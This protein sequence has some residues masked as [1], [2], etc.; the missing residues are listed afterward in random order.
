MAIVDSIMNLLT[1]QTIT[2]LADRLGAPPSAVQ[3]GIGTSITAL[4]IGIANRGRDSDFVSQVFDLVKG[5]D[6]QDILKTLPNLASGAGASS[7]A[8]EE[9]MKLSSLVL[10]GQQSSI[11]NFIGRQSGLT[12][13]AGRELMSLAAALTAGFLGYRVRDTGLAAFSFAYTIRS[14]ASKI[15]GLLPPGLP[16]LL[17]AV[18]I[19][20]ELGTAEGSAGKGGGRK[21]AYALIGLLLLVLIAWLVSHGGN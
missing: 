1:R 7:A 5:A 14:E 13:D 21:L 19:P 15:Q 18:S 11:E 3:M 20:A 4:L 8:M 12:A 9:G 17:A 10:R 2:S 16:N 6:T